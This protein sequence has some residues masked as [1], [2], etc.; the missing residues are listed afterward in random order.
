MKNT[1][2]M[3]EALAKWREMLEVE[4]TREVIIKIRKITKK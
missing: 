3:M 2:E 1:K 4:M